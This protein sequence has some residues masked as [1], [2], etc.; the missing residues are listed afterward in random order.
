MHIDLHTA[1]KSLSWCLLIITGHAILILDFTYTIQVADSKFN[2][3][4]RP[5][6]SNA[7]VH[8]QWYNYTCN[9]I[10]E[11]VHYVS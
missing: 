7:Q 10:A 11:N 4:V 9:M 5:N 8:T 2:V 3:H 6:Y 1:L